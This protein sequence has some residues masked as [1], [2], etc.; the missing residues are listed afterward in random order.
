MRFLSEKTFILS[1]LSF[2][3]ISLHYTMIFC[4]CPQRSRRLEMYT[5]IF[6]DCLHDF[7]NKKTPLK[8]DDVKN[9]RMYLVGGTINQK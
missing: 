3:Q 5:R 9:R 4:V 8:K 1:A 2:P 6:A 7:P